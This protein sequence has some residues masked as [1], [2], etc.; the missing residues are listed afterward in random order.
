MKV[1]GLNKL[2]EMLNDERIPRTL[3]LNLTKAIRN[4]LQERYD[5]AI[6]RIRELQKLMIDIK[7]SKKQVLKYEKEALGFITQ[8][9]IPIKEI[10]G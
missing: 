6:K 7:T 5:L 10:L 8:L 3:C 2:I 9:S 1:D 4:E